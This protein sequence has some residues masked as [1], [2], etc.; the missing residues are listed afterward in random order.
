MCCHVTLGAQARP[1]L[2]LFA[3]PLCSA[4]PD[5]ARFGRSEC[6]YQTFEPVLQQAIPQKLRC[7]HTAL[8]LAVSMSSI[9][10]DCFLVD[11]TIRMFRT[12]LGRKPQCTECNQQDSG[13][14]RM[15]DSKRSNLM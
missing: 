6:T 3:H 12:L 15:R 1:Y 7:L 10:H 4:A 2:M 5:G 9:L 11:V 13:A 14:C 8:L